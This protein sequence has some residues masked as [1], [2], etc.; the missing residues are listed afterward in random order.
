[1]RMLQRE[2]GDSIRSF[3]SSP[4]ASQSSRLRPS[5]LRCPKLRVRLRR[6]TGAQLV[7]LCSSLARCCF[8]GSRMVGLLRSQRGQERS[9][10]STSMTMTARTLPP[11]TPNEF[12]CQEGD[13]RQ[14]SNH[15]MLRSWNSQSR[16]DVGKRIARPSTS[17][18]GHTL[19]RA[20]RLRCSR[21]TCRLA[22]QSGVRTLRGAS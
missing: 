17:G 5:L 16:Q 2:I 4:L 13:L 7:S 14:L 8:G 19:L 22:S 15:G 9:P 3:G 21:P 12:V 1:M 10:S 6:G 20:R 11:N 18:G